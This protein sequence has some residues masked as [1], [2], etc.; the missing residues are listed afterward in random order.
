MQISPDPGGKWKMYNSDS[1]SVYFQVTGTRL[2]FNTGFT[3]TAKSDAHDASGRAINRQYT[4]T[5]SS[6]AFRAS[7]TYPYNGQTGVYLNPSIEGDFT[8]VLDTGTVRGAFSI[9]PA[10]PGSFY[11]TDTYSFFWYTCSPICLRQN[12]TYTVSVTSLLKCEDGTPVVPYT[13]TF[14]TDRFNVYSTYPYDGSTN[15]YRFNS[16]S[17]YLNGNIDTSSVRSAFSIS[18]PVPGG[19]FNL[20]DPNNSFYFYNDGMLADTTYTVTLSTALKTNAGDHLLSPYSF[21][22]TTGH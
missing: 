10:T 6:V 20:S 1:F 15:I 2:P 21:S 7:A 3:L 18:P 13:I 19:N 16:I 4:S 8:G 22:F 17:I 5:F 11:I 9:N 12:T 14:T